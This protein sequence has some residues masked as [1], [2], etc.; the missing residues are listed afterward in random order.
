MPAQ[1]KPAPNNPLY[2][3]SLLTADGTSYQLHS[4]TTS[5]T[6]AEPKGQIAQKATIRLVNVKAGDRWLSSIIKNR[7][8]LFV[9]ADIG[10]GAFE[11]FRGF[12]WD[13]NYKSGLTKE[14]SL[15]AFDN[16]IYF[17]ES[18]DSLFF[19]ADRSTQ[20]V[21]T[22]ICQKWG[23]S[24]TY[25]YDSIT[26]EKLVLRGKIA[27]ILISDLLDEVKNQTGKKYEIRSEADKIK[28]FEAGTNSTVYDVEA[29]KN[30]IE[31][32][33]KKTMS[34]M[35]TQVVITGKEDDEGRVPVEATASRNTDKYGT[36]QK[37][38]RKSEGTDLSEVQKEADTTLDEK[39]IPQETITV[40]FVDNPRIRR[41]DKV[42]VAAGN[43][44]DHFLVTGVTRNCDTKTATLELEKL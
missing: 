30:A 29:K 28:V 41:G 19:P 27:D 24:I 2:R 8:R 34:G 6:L 16:L 18:E 31:T 15:T 38:I 10:E 14:I 23:V 12:V 42:K 26:H 25:S 36:L 3:A 21:I 44:T 13:F 35:V 20:S 37:I 5:L 11:V 9:T 32:N 17:Q 22:D 7:D 33:M 1:P 4:A 40:D 39:A 43:L